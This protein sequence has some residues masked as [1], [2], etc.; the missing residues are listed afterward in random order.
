MVL[1]HSS[2]AHTC[3]EQGSEK[4]LVHC[5]SQSSSMETAWG[6]ALGA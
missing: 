4:G 6:I 1:R 2:A 5:I 3:A